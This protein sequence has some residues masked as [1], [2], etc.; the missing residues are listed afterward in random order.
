MQGIQDCLN[1]FHVFIVK[2]GQPFDLGFIDGIPIA[3]VS[4][5][6][7]GNQVI[8]DITSENPVTFTTGQKVKCEVDWNR[9][10]DFMQQHTAQASIL[11][12]LYNRGI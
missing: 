4:K 8:V 12:G 2:G 11:S 6:A 7:I 3:K 9:R 1:F 10:Y 5:G